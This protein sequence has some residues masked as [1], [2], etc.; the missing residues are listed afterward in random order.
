MTHR[1]SLSTIYSQFGEELGLSWVAGQAAAEEI[2]I[3][4]SRPGS[5]PSLVGFLNLI[6][7]NR[8]QVV[9]EEELSWLDGLDARTRWETL[10]RIVDAHPAAVIIAGGME[11][12][13]DLEQ[14]ARDSNTALLRAQ[15]PAWELVH[16]LESRIARALAPKTTLHGVFMEVFTLGVLITGEPG[17]GKSELALE[18]VSRGHRLIADD[19]PEFTKITP[20]TIEGT[21]PDL[22][23]DYLE[24]RGLGLLNIRRMF[25]DAAI[26]TSKYLRLIIHLHMPDQSRDKDDRLRGNFDVRDVLELEIPQIHVPVLAGRNLAVM[27]EVAVRDFMLRLKGFDAG[28]EFMERHAA[29]MSEDP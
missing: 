11:V 16:F 14:A 10:A 2:W 23:R 21:C 7:P 5:R 29:L 27:A 26:K 24:V 9:G 22:L 15:R 13:R 28:R 1:L 17:T 8:I 6:H 3:G 20:D 12:A 19:A 18:L 25:G 4:S